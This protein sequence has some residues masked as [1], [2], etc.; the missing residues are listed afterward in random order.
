MS[1][2]FV[3]QN[4]TYRKTITLVRSKWGQKLLSLFVKNYFKG[5]L[6]H[7]HATQGELSWSSMPNLA[8]NEMKRTTISE[9]YHPVSSHKLHISIP[10]NGPEYFWVDRQRHQVAVG[11]YMVHLP[12]QEVLAEAQY[13]R[14]VDGLCL[15]L[16]EQTLTEVY[17]AA[18]GTTE[19]E[20]GNSKNLPWN[21]N[22]FV[23]HKYSQ[24][25]HKLGKHIEFIL[26]TLQLETLHPQ[27][28]LDTLFYGVAEALV[29]QLFAV[30]T[31]L[32]QL[33]FAK[34]T[35]RQ[36]LYQRVSSAHGYV[37]DH[38][39]EPLSLN[40][41]AQIACI[42]PYHLLRLYKQIYG[43][44][45]HQ[46]ILQLRMEKARTMLSA[47]YSCSEIAFELSFSDRR[48]FSRVFRKMVGVTPEVWRKG[49]GLLHSNLLHK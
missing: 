38:F 48:A 13:A 33:P 6:M 34:N 45:P 20:I 15:F 39:A 30:Q 49:A 11:Q 12:G 36:A 46:H 19:L 29:E 21:K 17:T 10:I 41:L 37:L 7:A 42:S 1:D 40:A 24:G 26:H 28:E 5:A 8:G 2:N 32:D 25:G 22:Q 16:S 27:V 44:P 3:E 23:L 43:I 18:K 35:T 9:I 14:P 4:Q 31:Q 47:Q